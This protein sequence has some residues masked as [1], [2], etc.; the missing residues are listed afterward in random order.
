MTNSNK[1]NEEIDENQVTETS[2][3]FYLSDKKIMLNLALMMV[4]WTVCSFNFYLISYQLKYFPGSVYNNS[5]ASSGADIGAFAI[6]GFIYTYAGMRLSTVGFFTLSMIGGLTIIIFGYEEHMP[7]WHFPVM[8]LCTKFGV[9]CM[10][11][12]VYIANA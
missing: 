1:S 7:E 11:N 9:S 12:L 4:I 2:I 6:S 8:V 3:K 5:M 10:F